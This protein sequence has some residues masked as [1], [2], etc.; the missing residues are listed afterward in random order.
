MRGVLLKKKNGSGIILTRDGLFCRGTVG[1]TETLGDEVTVEP[2]GK[3]PLPRWLAAAALALACFGFGIYRLF[4]PP[5]WAH[6]TLDVDPSVELTLDSRLVVTEEQGLNAGGKRLLALAGAR[7]RPLED[8]V[9]RLLR[10]AF[11]AGYIRER[12]CYVVLVTVMARQGDRRLDPEA[13]AS[14]VAEH[15]PER[16]GGLEIVAVR[17]GKGVRREAAKAGLSSGRYL[18]QQEFGR[19]GLAVAPELLRE[20]SLRRIEEKQGLTVAALVG[21]SGSVLVRA[22]EGLSK[23][24]PMQ[25]PPVFLAAPVPE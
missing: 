4:F 24:G 16:R 25:H 11:T 14:L 22:G 18:L 6:L 20:E 3:R 1:E 8:A 23:K 12:D 21:G 5:A 2:P 7:G 17:V 15:F 13:L 9:A 10:R 19:R